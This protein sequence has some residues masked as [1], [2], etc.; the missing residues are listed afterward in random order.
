MLIKK[1]N[2]AGKPVITATQ[3]LRSMV[4]S[5][6][7]TR[8]EATDVANAVLDG[9]DAVMLSEET[10]IGKYPVQAV[11][12]MS[13]IIQYA[14]EDFPYIDYLQLLPRKSVSE[15]VAQASCVLADHLDAAVIIAST[16]SGRTAMNI[17]RFR[18]R[19][20]IIAF[21]P[22]PKT[23]LKLTLF[24]GCIP[25]VIPGV[26]N[27]D[28]MIETAAATAREGGFVSTGDLAVITAGQPVWT[29][30]TTNMV[31]VKEID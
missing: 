27:T 14:E 5:P 9:T 29:A 20:P 31:R 3:M 18:P 15:S 8:A 13:R 28:E 23:V 19:Q 21:S 16:Q 1:A 26:Q 30:G 7:P 25:R 17:S 6:R 11:R 22:N 10:A 24:W 12:F 2:L 4:D